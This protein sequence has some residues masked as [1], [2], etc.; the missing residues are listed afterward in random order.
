MKRGKWY[1]P[2][3]NGPYGY[4]RGNRAMQSK[5]V[6]GKSANSEMLLRIKL[7]EERYGGPTLYNSRTGKR[8]ALH[9]F[10]P[11]IPTDAGHREIVVHND[12]TLSGFKLR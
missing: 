1:S 12:S 10:M 8:V 5:R 6:T 4:S 9:T 2:P 11:D 3:A 7:Q